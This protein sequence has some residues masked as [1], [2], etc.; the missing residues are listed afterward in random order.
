[1]REKLQHVMT[2]KWSNEFKFN[3]MQYTLA[4]DTYKKE[5][6]TVCKVIKIS[7]FIINF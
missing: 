3:E 4:R 6:Q 5:M 2:Y 1:M 7:S